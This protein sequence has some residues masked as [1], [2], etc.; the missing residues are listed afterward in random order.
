MAEEKGSGEIIELTEVVEEAPGA[1][2]H[3]G[4]VPADLNPAPKPLFRI[5]TGFPGAPPPAFPLVQDPAAEFERL[6]EALTRKTEA[7]IASEGPRILERA[8]REMFPKIAQEVL[9]Q[10]IEKIK[11]EAETEEKE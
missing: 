6:K 4:G 10:E 3:P 8:A 7:W 9:R 2:K 11:T 1:M 5:Q